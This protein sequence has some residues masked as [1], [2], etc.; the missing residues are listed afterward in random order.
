MQVCASHT[1][2]MTR[3]ERVALMIAIKRDGMLTLTHQVGRTWIAK[4][5][6]QHLPAQEAL[7]PGQFLTGPGQ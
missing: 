4:N 1:Q 7:T 6:K 5:K 2:G 3:E